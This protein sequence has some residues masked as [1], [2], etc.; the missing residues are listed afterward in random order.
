[1]KRY[2]GILIL[3]GVSSCL[4][5]QA[6][7]IPTESIFK[8]TLRCRRVRIDGIFNGNLIVEEK[9]EISED[10]DVKGTIKTVDGVIKGKV[11]GK[12][13]ASKHLTITSTAMVSGDVSCRHLVV[14]EGALVSAKTSMG[15]LEEIVKKKKVV[16]KKKAAVT[17]RR[18]RRRRY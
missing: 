3:L 9:F 11:D 12:I 5:A 8:G 6:T 14:E 2:A 10:G 18:R 4:F 1:M 16:K 13:F 7:L 17:T 15:E